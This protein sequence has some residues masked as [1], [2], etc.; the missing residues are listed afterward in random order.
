EGQSVSAK[1]ARA[2]RDAVIRETYADP[3]SAHHEA[4]A[5]AEI[6]RSYAGSGA[7]TG[8]TSNGLAPGDRLPDTPPV[9]PDSGKPCALHELTH[10]P[11]HTLLVLGGREA[12]ADDVHD[13]VTALDAAYAGSPVVGAVLGLCAE[14]A[15][16]PIGRIDASVADQLGIEN[17]T[18]L[19]VRPDRFIGFRH[20]RQDP[21]A[22]QA[23]LGALSADA[24]IRTISGGTL[25]A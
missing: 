11:D 1:Q 17:V 10:R 5:A 6:D 13:L 7:V 14:P 9:H 20:D 12:S 25:R 8:D 24:A 15:G 16:L 21:G 23:Y 2:A 4:V 22:L 19:A 3:E 18:V